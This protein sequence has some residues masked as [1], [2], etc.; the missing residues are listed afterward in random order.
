MIDSIKYT[1]EEQE[2]IQSIL[3]KKDFSPKNWSDVELADLKHRIKQYYI[4]EQ[5]FTCPYCQQINRTRHGRAWDIEH[6]ISRDQEPNFMFEA[7][8]LCASCIDCNGEKSNKKVT[9][10][11]AK[12]HYPINSASYFFIH[13][14][15]D[16]YKEYILVIEEGMFYIAKK[17]KGRKTIEICGLNR[18][19]EFS[20]YNDDVDLDDKIALLSSSLQQTTDVAVKNEIYKKIT[21]ISLKAILN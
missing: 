16:D 17:K 3:I 1:Q 6:I 20:G 11:A 2:L 9:K 4:S 8:N 14:H 10:S 5:K 7:Q 18:F 19:Y 13:P 21:A 12:K 15:F